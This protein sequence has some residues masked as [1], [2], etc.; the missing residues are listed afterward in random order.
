M[1]TPLTGAEQ[2]NAAGKLVLPSASATPVVHSSLMQSAAISQYFY[3]NNGQLVVNGDQLGYGYNDTI[4][5][6]VNSAY[7]VYVNLN[8]TVASFGWNVVKSITVNT[9][10]GNNA[11]YVNN[12]ASAVPLTINDGGTDYVRVGSN[13]S[14]QGIRGVVSINNP[15]YYTNLVIDDSADTYGRAVSVGSTYVIGLSYSG[16]QFHYNDL[17]YL[18]LMGGSGNNYI[19]VNNTPSTYTGTSAGYTYLMSG[20]GSDIV[21]VL[22]TAGGP[23]AGGLYI[24]GYGGGDSVYV[25]NNSS[26]VGTGGSLA[27]INGSVYVYNP[28]GATRLF[29]DDSADTTSRNATLTGYTLT[30]LSNGTIYLAATPSYSGGV[31]DLTIYGSAASS[32]YYVTGSP[33]LFDYTDLQTGAGND[34]VIIT[35]TTG[36]MTT[37]N[38]GGYDSVYVGNG[39]LAGINGSVYASGAGSTYLYVLDYNDTT[40]NHNVTLGSNYLMGLSTGVIWWAPSSTAMGGV[41]YL[42][43][44]GSSSGATYSVA[45]TPNLLYSTDLSTGAGS[46]VIY[47]TGTTGALNL[48]N[49]GGADFV[50]VGSDG[51]TANING[52]VNV[53]GAGSTYLYVEDDLDPVA[54]NVTLTGSSL[55]GM[56]QGTITWVASS[57]ATGGVVFLNIDGSNAGGTYTITDTPNLYYYT[58]LYTGTGSDT[59]YITGTTSSLYVFNGGGTDTVVIGSQPSTTSGGNVGAINGLVYVYGYGPTSVNVDDSGDAT[60]RAI[61]LTSTSLTGLAPGYI[62]F[63]TNVSSLTINAGTGND[64]LTVADTSLAFPV[65]FNGGNG[66]DTLVGANNYQYWDITGMNAG[67]I[68]GIVSFANVENLVGGT[69]VDTFWLEPGAQVASINGGGAPAGQGDWLDYANYPGAVTV[70]LATGQATGVTGPVSNI[71]NVFGGNFGNTLTGSS[72]G[73]ILIGGDGAD[74]IIGG[75]GRS[76]LIGGRGSDTIVGGAADDIVIGGY[77]SYGSAWNES[78][79]MSFLAEWQSADAYATR[80][81]SLR[82]GWHSLSPGT[83]VFDDGSVDQLTGAGGMD[84][85][86]TGLQDTITD[87]QG[88]EAVN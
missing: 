32:T 3:F 81:S 42:K 62:Y 69:S 28:Y 45:D 38:R 66:N 86:M 24:N 76:L 68:A 20:T 77:T 63:G 27:N 53:S 46:D 17:S 88:G 59:V 22:G 48:S 31:T 83:T 26:F 2:L 65:I 74:L 67:S 78:A 49:L 41:T 40:A 57:A 21:N 25:G 37:Y 84:W 34:S 5:I 79:L 43:I 18:T 8:G 60:G 39:S 29:V 70:N 58:S 19:T 23:Y 13:G 52:S 87:Y 55:T 50:Y 16:I 4:T 14:A 54:R 47:I 1:F 35:G 30:G 75:S 73:N 80:I 12:E 10:A 7:G 82:S 11:V 72:Q 51:S 33:N 61:T 44:V 56:S 71:Q 85:F 9:G 64:T 36:F 6:D 15:Y